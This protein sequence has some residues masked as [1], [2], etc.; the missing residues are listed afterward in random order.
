MC[1]RDGSRPPWH[2]RPEQD[3]VPAKAAADGSKTGF[4][5]RKSDLSAAP[6]RWP[7]RQPA[8]MRHPRVAAKVSSKR[9][10]NTGVPRGTEMFPKNSVATPAMQSSVYGLQRRRSG[11]LR[12]DGE[13]S[14]FADAVNRQFVDKRQAAC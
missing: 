8:T 3:A 13:A 6:S 1:A 14:R 9:R 10:T 12:P 11:P 4:G 2:E 7:S 5:P